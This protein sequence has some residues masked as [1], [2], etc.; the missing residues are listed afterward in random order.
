MFGSLK[1]HLLSFVKALLTFVNIGLPNVV[2]IYNLW[3]AKKVA[4]VI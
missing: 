2:E 3:V 4:Y 1:I